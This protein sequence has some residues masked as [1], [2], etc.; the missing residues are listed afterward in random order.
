MDTVKAGFKKRTQVDAVC[1]QA[2][3]VFQ[4]RSVTASDEARI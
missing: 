1:I 4:G 2:V 3:A